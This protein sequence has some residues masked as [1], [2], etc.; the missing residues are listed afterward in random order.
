MPT[1]LPNILGKI[2]VLKESLTQMVGMS[3]LESTR[4]SGGR[5]RGMGEKIVVVINA[6][7]WKGLS[8]GTWI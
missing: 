3:C 6:R 4:R 7:V 1:Y 8:Y 2:T 5:T